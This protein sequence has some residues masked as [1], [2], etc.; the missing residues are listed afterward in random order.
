MENFLKLLLGKASRLAL[1]IWLIMFSLVLPST[2]LA[3]GGTIVFVGDKGPFNITMIMS[4]SPANP[5][6]PT[7]ID[8]IMTKKGTDQPV[9][10]ATIIVLP[11]MPGMAMPGVVGQRF[12]QQQGRPNQYIVDMPL[13]M[14]GLWRLN[15]TISDP[16]LGSTEYT[17][18][19]KVE[20]IDA[21]WAVIV[22]ILVALPVLAGLT[23][24]FLFRNLNN[25]DDNDDDDDVGRKNRKQTK[26]IV[27]KEL[28]VGT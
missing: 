20:K 10:S 3:N 1:L 7:H 9:T 14:E 8:I 22:G 12:S 28:E 13:T 25:D 19:A 5:D 2:S 21:P 17:F 4:P 23:W 27:S 26:Q 11:E 18:D 16:Q 15:I 6:V 24:W